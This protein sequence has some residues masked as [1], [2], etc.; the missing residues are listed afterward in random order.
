[1]SESGQ[2]TSMSAC[3]C[4]QCI[5]NWTNQRLSNNASNET[6]AAPDTTECIYNIQ[7]LSLASP[8]ITDQNQSPSGLVPSTA[9]SSNDNEENIERWMNYR[10]ETDGHESDSSENET[11]ETNDEPDS[12]TEVSSE[13]ERIEAQYELCPLNDTDGCE[14]DCPYLHGDICHLCHTHRL[15][16]L[17]PDEHYNACLEMHKKQ[18]EDMECNICMEKVVEIQTGNLFGIQENCN[19]CF[20]SQCI[21]VWQRNEGMANNRAC[22]VCR[23]PSGLV[24]DFKYWIT[25]PISKMKLIECKKL[26]VEEF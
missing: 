5:Q 19:H 11:N 17:D 2:E 8:D 7:S 6:W 12:P 26:N 4:V 14:D 18:S 20:C 15:D 22:P 23:T 13:D 25:C 24:F 16:P 10:G 21:E 9:A 3:R 1:M